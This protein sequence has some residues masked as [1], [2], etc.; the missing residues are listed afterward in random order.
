MSLFDPS[1]RTVVYHASIS[2]LG[3]RLRAMVGVRA[4]AEFYGKN[5]RICWE[6]SPGCDIKFESLFTSEPGVQLP[7]AQLS[8]VSSNA[9][10][11]KTGRWFTDIVDEHVPA[12]NRL[13]CYGRALHHL[14]SLRPL[15]EIES[16]IQ[17][18]AAKA[19][20]NERCGLH[21]RLTDH[22][23]SY[24]D[25]ARNPHFR[26]DHVSLLNGFVN[27]IEDARLQHSARG[28]FLATDSKSTEQHLEASFAS[29][30]ICYPKAWRGSIS[31]WRWLANPSMLY[32]Y[33][34]QE[35]VVRTSTVREALIDLF[36][37]SRCRVLYGSYYSSFSKLAALLGT[38][39][40][41]E[42][43][44]DTPTRNERIASLQQM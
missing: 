37:L 5:F 42:V 25:F 19:Q 12:A 33:F 3:N 39:P 27:A 38:S 18:F 35:R 8:S 7:A 20:L 34:R 16:E 17:S 40:F 9:V 15:P 26:R 22:A 23:T 29:E 32:R 1:I 28:I 43:L 44:G 14:R 13:S 4:C 6:P 10:I 31:A 21:I 24:D 2:G 41:F 36:L 11:I 30:V